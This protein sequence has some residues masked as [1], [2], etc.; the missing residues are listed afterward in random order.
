MSQK[1]GQAFFRAGTRLEAGL[2]A[3]ISMQKVMEISC[4]KGLELGSK[5]VLSGPRLTLAN[6]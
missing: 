4:S 2:R 6:L 5:N 3:I 1:L